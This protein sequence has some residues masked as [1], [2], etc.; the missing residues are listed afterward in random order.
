MKRGER[1]GGEKKE[2]AKK[3]PN[4]VLYGPLPTGSR[5]NCTYHNY[6]H[7]RPRFDDLTVAVLAS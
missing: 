7:C 4:L 2:K 3:S 1:K 5:Q 6:I